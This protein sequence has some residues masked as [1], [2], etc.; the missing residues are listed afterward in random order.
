MKDKVIPRDQ[1]IHG[2]YYRGHC[3]GVSVARW[4]GEQKCFIYR[5]FKLGQHSLEAVPHIQE[6]SGADVFVPESVIQP[7][8]ITADLVISFEAY[9]KQEKRT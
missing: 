7:E 8:K 3:R 1:M 9:A 2:F 4:H 5:Q 6:G